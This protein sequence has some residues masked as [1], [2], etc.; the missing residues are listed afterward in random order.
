[1]LK[2]VLLV[3][4][5]LFLFVP[6]IVSAEDSTSPKCGGSVG[7][8]GCGTTTTIAT[9]YS[10]CSETDNGR[11]IYEWGTCSDGTVTNVPDECL[12]LSTLKEWFCY[13]CHPPFCMSTE[14]KCEFGCDI[15]KGVCRKSYGNVPLGTCKDFDVDAAHPDGKNFDVQSICIDA[16]GHG[17][18]DDCD[19]SNRAAEYFCSSGSCMKTTNWCPGGCTNSIC[20]GGEQEKSGCCVNPKTSPC[21][22]NQ[23]AKECCPADDPKAYATGNENGPKDQADCLKNWFF[24]Y[25]ADTCQ[26][27]SVACAMMNSI[28]FANWN[29]CTKGCC[30]SHSP[31]D[32]WGGNQRENVKCTGEGFV[33]VDFAT[34]GQC[35]SN[36]CMRYIQ[37]NPLQTTTT[38]V[39]SGP[40]LNNDR[41]H[42]GILNDK[43]NCPD[44][45]N[46]D[47]LDT[48]GDSV[49]D[50]CDNCVSEVNIVQTD[51]DGDKLGDV[52][53]NCPDVANADQK[54]TDKDGKGDAC[55]KDSSSENK[56]ILR[57]ALIG[58][59]VGVI[60]GL[61]VWLALE[62]PAASMLWGLGIGAAAGVI[63]GLILKFIF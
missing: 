62:L 16:Q 6:I 20:Q 50:A 29:E 19:G 30:C 10:G 43:D 42:D 26:E 11:K 9:P 14:E 56:N 23:V 41:D 51:S 3:L 54:D 21:T 17:F 7:G 47:Q 59:I 52:C 39:T 15:D 53:D 1:M 60:V 45:Q 38:T 24:Y 4:L 18:V 63:L 34:I 36:S 35:D 58:A 8:V 49:G 5:I 40:S 55:A 27:G 46:V 33:W 28:N 31:D 44:I 37:S 22:Y 48:D 61:I 2:R 12:S 13:Q 32:V 57:L 25:Q